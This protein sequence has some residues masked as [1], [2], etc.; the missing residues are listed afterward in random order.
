LLSFADNKALDEKGF[1]CY[2]CDENWQFRQTSFQEYWTVKIEFRR[3]SLKGSDAQKDMLSTDGIEMAR[4]VGETMRGKGFTHVVVSSLFRTAQTA[5]AFA[6]GAGDMAAAEMLVSSAMIYAPE[7][8]PE[9]VAY[10]QGEN[11]DPE[12]PLIKK[13]AVRMAQEF[14]QQV[15]DKLPSNAQV[16]AVGHSPMIECLIFG[17]MGERVAPLKECEGVVIE[18]EGEENPEFKIK[19][20]IHF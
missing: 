15:Q 18:A 6:E 11:R 5:A 4:K 2:I 7:L 17:L 19:E 8:F 9:W 20:E 14:R 1:F 3:H 10:C 16:L 13:E 12:H